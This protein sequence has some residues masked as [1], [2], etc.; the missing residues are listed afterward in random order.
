VVLGI[1]LD[2]SDVRAGRGE[3]DCGIAAEGPDLEDVFCT[4]ELALD[5]EVLALQGRNGYGGKVVGSGVLQGA[6]EERVWGEE[7]GDGEGVDFGG[8]VEVVDHF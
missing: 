5:G 2:G 1:D 3:P 4:E 6:V 8:A 7:A